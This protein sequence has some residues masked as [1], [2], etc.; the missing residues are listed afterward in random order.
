M[1]NFIIV[2]IVIVVAVTVGA[3]GNSNYQEVTSI[4]DQ[5]HLQLS[6]EDCKRLFDAGVELDKCF[7]KSINAFG[8]DEQQNLWKR[9][10]YKP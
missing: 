4:R 2:V 1:N 6:L 10:E 5:K 9:G 8:T 3:M 7:E